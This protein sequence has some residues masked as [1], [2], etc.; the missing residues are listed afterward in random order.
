MIK[1]IIGKRIID[2]K[3]LLFK[4]HDL[5]SMREMVMNHV[6]MMNVSEPKYM[7]TTDLKT[8]NIVENVLKNNDFL[9]NNVLGNP[10]SSVKEL[11]SHKVKICDINNYP[12][13]LKAH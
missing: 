11:A 10:G 4:N 6:D 13:Y 1:N 12:A 3:S 7:K 8:L 5:P 9:R 2:W